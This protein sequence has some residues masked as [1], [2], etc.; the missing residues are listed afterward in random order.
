M[1][2]L[3]LAK[4]RYSC[5]KFA[6]KPVEDDKLNAIIQA[7]VA[8]PTAKNVQPVKLWVIKSPDALAK[9]KS[10]TPFKWMDNVPVVIA[11]GGTTDG[12]FVRPSDN[13]NFQ[14]VDASII[15]THIMLAVEA[16]GLGTTWVGFFDINKVHELFPE[17]KGYDLVAL[18]PIGYK[19]QDA[20][21]S[22]RHSISMDD[23][24]KFL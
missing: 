4:D 24:V 11:V 1:D 21:P 7:A 13:R 2:F 18:F 8:A 5:R 23:M 14:D 20:M 16:Q 10:C 17:M 3:K 12:A 22:D 19:A 15:A 6:D 9:I